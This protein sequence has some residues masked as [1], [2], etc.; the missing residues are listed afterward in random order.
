[1]KARS[2]IERENRVNMV[3]AFPLAPGDKGRSEGK[4]K[5]LVGGAGV[6]IT[7]FSRPIIMWKPLFKLALLRPA[8]RI[9]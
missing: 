3:S 7:Q 5:W 8:H 2:I 6:M 4:K 9:R 1:M